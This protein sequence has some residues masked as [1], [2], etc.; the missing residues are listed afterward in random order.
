[1]PTISLDAGGSRGV[2]LYD[3]YAPS[4]ASCEPILLAKAP[5]AELQSAC[6]VWLMDGA[7]LSL[8]SA[9]GRRPEAAGCVCRP[10]Q[11]VRC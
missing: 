10:W 8:G 6:T 5:D 4:G 2:P 7:T 11:A 3:I 9:G 1:M